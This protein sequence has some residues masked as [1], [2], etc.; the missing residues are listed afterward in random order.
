MTADRPATE[1]RTECRHPYIE[2]HRNEQHDITMWSCDDC[3]RR[4]YPAC[5]KCVSVGH[6]E[7]HGEHIE[8]EAARG[9]A[10]RA[11]CHGQCDNEWLTH[12]DPECPLFEGAAPRAE[13]LDAE[14]LFRAY[15]HA[16]WDSGD[17][18]PQWEELPEKKR[19]W[20]EAVAVAARLSRPSD[21]RVPEEEA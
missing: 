20:W 5:E 14:Y 17:P 13:G 19:S 8:A 9:A 4:F 21:E 3:H 11:E 18:V 7:G 12:D 2:R 6:R 15:W 16:R 1:P 10:P